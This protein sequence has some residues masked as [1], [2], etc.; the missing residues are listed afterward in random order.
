MVGK[1]NQ[2][3]RCIIVLIMLNA[4]GGELLLMVH[5]PDQFSLPCGGMHSIKIL[6]QRSSPKA[7]IFTIAHFQATFDLYCFENCDVSVWCSRL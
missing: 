3:D 7:F 2:A 4:V 5:Q 1:V 6:Y